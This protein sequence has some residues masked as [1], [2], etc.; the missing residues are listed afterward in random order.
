MSANGSGSGSGS[1]SFGPAS[2][3]SI[4]VDATT[5]TVATA[6]AWN[7]HDAAAVASFFAPEG[8]LRDWDV[9]VTGAD[10]VGAAN[11]KIFEA[12]PTIRIEVRSVY[13]SYYELWRIQ[14]VCQINV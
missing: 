13:T 10:N 3:I 12:V 2:L 9:S 14:H 7:T 6:D 1:G 5:A 8:S 11:G 4:A